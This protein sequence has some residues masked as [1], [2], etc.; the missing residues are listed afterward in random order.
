MIEQIFSPEL[1]QALG[2]TLVH[3]LWQAA[4][5]ALLLGVAL[6]LLRKYSARTR[7]VTA[8]GVLAAF[9][10]TTL[11]TFSQLYGEEAPLAGVETAMTSAAE[12][13]D[14]VAI[15]PEADKAGEPSGS[16]S[17][18][19]ETS[20]ISTASSGPGF[21]ERVINY[22]NEHLPLIVTLWL[23]GVLIL[24]LRFLGQLAFLQRLKNYGTERFPARLAPILQELESKLGI[25]KPVRYLTSFRVGSPFT[26]GWL[27]P[28]VLF[29]RGLLGELDEAQLRTIIAHELAH[30][31]R[32]DF[33][34]NLIQTLLCILF[35]YHPAAWW[36]SA[37]IDEEREH[38]C[39]DLAI[40]VTGEAVGYARTLLQLKESE[41]AGSPLAMGVLGRGD[42][43]KDRITRLLSGY[44]GTGTYGEGFTTAVI[45]F[46]FMGLAVTLSAQ[47]RTDMAERESTASATSSAPASAPPAELAEVPEN[48]TAQEVRQMEVFEEIKAMRPSETEHTT[49]YE[50]WK[51]Q[52]ATA[53][54]SDSLEFPFLMEAIK[55][56]S[57]SM[58]AY[59]LEKDID[60]N[61]TNRNG[62]TPLALAAGE[63]RVD[64]IRLLIRKGADVNYVSGR[65]W[66]ALIEAADEG[67]FEAAKELLAAGA[68]T[69]LPGT[70]R[71]AADMAASEGHPDILQL[72]A[73]S[74]ADISGKGRETSPLHQ[75]AEEGQFFVVQSLLQ[76]GADA[77]AKDASGRTA[78]SYA[79]EEGH[80][81]VAALLAAQGH[82]NATD[83]HGR[84]PI[85]YAAEE[86]H[87]S[88]VQILQTMGGIDTGGD[89][90]GLTPLHYAAEEGIEGVVT[91]LLK[92]GA[93]VDAKDARGRTAL[94]YAAAEGDLP[95]V[96]QLLK[97]GADVKAK[98]IT[99]YTALDYAL[100]E[101]LDMLDDALANL[102]SGM[103]FNEQT[104]YPRGE[105]VNLVWALLDAGATSDRIHPQKKWI[106]SSDGRVGFPYIL[107]RD[108]RTY[109]GGGGV[110]VGQRS[111]SASSEIMGS[112]SGRVDQKMTERLVRAIDDDDADNYDDLLA[113]GADVNGNSANGFT[114][115]TMASH[116]NHNIDTDRLLRAGADINRADDRGYTPLTEAAKE[117]HQSTVRTLLERGANPDLADRKGNAAKDYA[118]REGFVQILRLLNDAGASVTALDEEGNSP[119]SLPAREGDAASVGFLLE[120]GVDPNAGRGCHPVFLAAREGHP[121]VIRILAKGGADLEKGC[122]FRD[123]DFFGRKDSPAEGT[124]A[125][126][127]NSSPLIVALTESDLNSARALLT[128]GANVNTPCRKLRFAMKRMPEN[129]MQLENLTEEELRQEHELTYEASNWTPLMEAAETGKIALVQLLLN[130]GADKRRRTKEGMSAYDVALAG[131]FTEMAALLK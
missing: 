80:G 127:H 8:I 44:L 111:V 100:D 107:D 38:C 18:S 62:L 84:T 112:R 89:R 32:Y 128:A 74:G 5:F 25:T 27:R 6:L 95:V 19:G 64:I 114:P 121:E 105:S 57:E 109:R 20:V 16:P 91:K 17:A 60:F 126:Y 28:A 124:I 54:I 9:C 51:K 76:A 66:T 129:W 46:C 33:L 50:N 12:N 40:E 49:A 65:G 93:D 71:S 26:A 24:Q 122:S 108:A 7:Y 35:F 36:I 101:M 14:P 15:E 79:A 88:I 103:T 10:L 69:D 98:D 2:W 82:V 81:A 102:G 22:Y 3:T 55:E 23:M 90:E 53:P 78:L 63:N 45:L 118:L 92:D 61:Q 110:H 67:A 96:R 47:D 73:E 115:L 94:H 48:R 43:F 97:A 56:G 113:A 1:I 39:D 29:P 59:F 30:I 130:A 21:R 68:K 86:G 117:G 119:L 87:G 13:S 4:L 104:G 116:E 77:G 99:Q 106:R 52:A 11:L 125:I 70:S 34:V 58:V 120:Q 31:K 42:G 131:G 37:R 123:T 85:S 72:L 83:R 41:L 75:A